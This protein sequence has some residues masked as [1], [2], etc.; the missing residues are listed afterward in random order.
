MRRL[1]TAALPLCVF[2]LLRGTATRASIFSTGR[3][4]IGSFRVNH[5][6]GGNGY[7]SALSTRDDDGPNENDDRERTI[8][9]VVAAIG[10][11]G[12]PGGNGDDDNAA[13]T[14]EARSWKR[15][16]KLCL[17]AGEYAE[18]SR[19]FRRGAERC[20]RDEGL[21]HHAKVYRAFHADDDGCDGGTT[22]S[23]GP[24]ATAPPQPPA[25]PRLEDYSGKDDTF[26]SLDVPP[27]NVPNSVL[28]TAAKNLGRDTVAEKDERTT[29]T[30]LLH[31]SKEPILSRDACRYI[32]LCAD[33]VAQRR[34]WTTDRHVHAPT[35]DMPAFDLDAVTVQWVREAMTRVLFPLLARAFPDGM[36]VAADKLRVQDLFVV[37]Y[38]GEEGESG[39]GFASLRPHEDESIISVTIALNDMSEYEG[40]GLFVACTGDLLNG[41]AGTVLTFAG[42]LVHGGYPV[43]RGTRWIMTVFLYLDENLSRKD[44]GYI[45]R[46]IDKKTVTESRKS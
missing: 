1:V 46:R 9:D 43:T 2:A 5:R 38:D 17:D 22:T 13:A 34:G 10:D 19:I 25:L 15:L 37:R 3:P 26:L 12:G 16:G 33:E 35:C 20:P 24:D 14:N 23:C 45:L 29:L 44:P 31:A 28:A 11:R 39:P 21:C 7:G 8:N 42:E 32:I 27:E 41:D 6:H 40:G 36:G 18:A 4:W 30:K